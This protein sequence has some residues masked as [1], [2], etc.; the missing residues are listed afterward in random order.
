VKQPFIKQAAK[1]KEDYEKQLN[2]WEKKMIEKGHLD[3]IRQKTLDE[4]S[5]KKQE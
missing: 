1:L 3:V 5:P 4:M 2:A